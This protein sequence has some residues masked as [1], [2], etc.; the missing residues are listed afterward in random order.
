MNGIGPSII[1]YLK[2]VSRL[3]PFFLVFFLVA[4]S[5]FDS[6]WGLNGMDVCKRPIHCT[7]LKRDIFIIFTIIRSKYH[8]N[9][10]DNKREH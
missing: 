3:S 7:D 8:G 5:L 6:Q 1:N 2:L 4:V 9:N 10:I